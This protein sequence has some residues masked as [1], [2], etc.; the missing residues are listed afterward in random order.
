MHLHSFSFTVLSMNCNLHSECFVG[1]TT[2]HSL[3]ITLFNL[4]ESFYVTFYVSHENW[5]LSIASFFVDAQ[6]TESAIL[7]IS[8]SVLSYLKT[9]FLDDVLISRTAG[10]LRIGTIDIE[11]IIAKDIFS[12]S[13]SIPVLYPNGCIRASQHCVL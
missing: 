7:I 6:L 13:R 9:S 2:T 5:S 11:D 10:S 4:A 8:I 1:P 12:L 3:N